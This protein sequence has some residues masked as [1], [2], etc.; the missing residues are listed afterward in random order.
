MGIKVIMLPFEEIIELYK[1][2]KKEEIEEL[3]K[4]FLEKAKGLIEIT[5]ERAIDEAVK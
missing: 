3:A 2:V 1:R 4:D 5:K